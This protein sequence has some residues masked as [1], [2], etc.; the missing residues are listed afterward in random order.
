MLFSCVL[1]LGNSYSL[2]V[3]NNFF[4]FLFSLF[5]VNRVFH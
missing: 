3:S 5:L 1:L 4:F 2:Q